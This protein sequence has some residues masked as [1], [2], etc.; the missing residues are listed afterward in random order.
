MLCLTLP[1]LATHISIL[2]GRPT[3]RVHLCS[4]PETPLPESGYYVHLRNKK[5]TNWWLPNH[6]IVKESAFQSST[7]DSKPYTHTSMST[8]KYPLP[9]LHLKNEIW[10]Q[11][12]WRELATKESSGSLVKSGG[13]YSRNL[14]MSLSSVKTRVICTLSYHKIM[15]LHIIHEHW[16][17]MHQLENL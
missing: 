2:I 9:L 14:H 12:I 4:G 10:T 15:C 7:Y 5:I 1:V 8:D 3:K 16:A 6:Q 17:I 11:R 13:V